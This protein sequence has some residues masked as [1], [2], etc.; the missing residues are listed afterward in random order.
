MRPSA[1]RSRRRRRIHRTPSG[2]RPLTGSSSTTT[3]GSP[4]NAAAIPSRWPM[5][6]E[7][8]PARRCAASSSPASSITSWTRRAGIRLLRA[9]HRRWFSAV[10]PGCTALVSSSAPTVR[11]GSRSCRYGVPPM[12]TSPAVGR[13]RPSIMRIVVDFPAPLGPRNPVTRPGRTRKPSP[14]TAVVFPY[15]LVRSVT[16]IMP[17]MV[18]DPRYPPHQA[19]GR[20]P[21]L[22]PREET[23]RHRGRASDRRRSAPGQPGGGGGA[24]YAW[25]GSRSASRY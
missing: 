20:R 19:R 21:F 24:P 3:A 14:S 13:F 9:R 17:V 25:L 6:S 7:N 12:R 5:P 22:H 8:V 18:R 16:S 1:A 15:R 4:S 2:S 10:R 11:S 23:G